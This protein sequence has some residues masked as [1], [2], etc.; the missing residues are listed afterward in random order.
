MLTFKHAATFNTLR[1]DGFLP[2]LLSRSFAGETRE[3][4]QAVIYQQPARFESVYPQVIPDLPAPA[5]VVL[6][7][8]GVP[9]REN[10]P[11][12]PDAAQCH[13]LKASMACF[14]LS[15]CSKPEP[16]H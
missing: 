2:Y 7:R 1:K 13:Q 15:L 9:A 5:Q 11:R 10:R 12:Q 3:G 4:E 14:M 6:K 8:S 16:I